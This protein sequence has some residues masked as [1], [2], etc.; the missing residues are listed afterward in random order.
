MSDILNSLNMNT[1]NTSTA[2]IGEIPFKKGANYITAPDSLPKY[3]IDKVLSERDEFRR[4]V[5]KE[6]NTANKVKENA[7]PKIVSIA[8]AAIASIL[9]M[10]KH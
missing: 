9:L 1:N 8:I 10:K 5:Q 2:Q 7:L 3:S 6:T 4:N